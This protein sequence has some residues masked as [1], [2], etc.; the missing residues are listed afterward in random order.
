VNDDDQEAV[1]CGNISDN[2]DPSSGL[3][4]SISIY[5]TLLFSGALSLLIHH[6]I[7]DPIRVSCC[8]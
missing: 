5:L 1:V 6:F 8:D 2:Q 4:R 7:L 3:W